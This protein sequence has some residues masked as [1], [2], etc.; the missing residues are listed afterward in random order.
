MSMC[1]SDGSVVSE[2]TG[3]SHHSSPITVY[4]DTGEGNGK[5]DLFDALLYF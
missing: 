3:L 2:H 4:R 5:Y 1:E